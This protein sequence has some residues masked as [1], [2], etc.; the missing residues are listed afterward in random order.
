[1][2]LSDGYQM[3]RKVKGGNTIAWSRR[4]AIARVPMLT[5]SYIER[6]AE[7]VALVSKFITEEQDG[8][9]QD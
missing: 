3:K 9:D 8:E 1:M 2:R 6:E 7:L 5:T 4:G